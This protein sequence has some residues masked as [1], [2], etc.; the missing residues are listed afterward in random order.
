MKA[1]A[2]AGNIDAAVETGTFRAEGTLALRQAVS[3]VWS[4]ELSDELHGRAVARYGQ[5]PGIT[6]VKG[7]SDAVLPELLGSIDEPA[8]FW[9]DAH[10]GM[11][12]MLSDTVFNPADEATQ[13]P[14]VAELQALRD[15]AHADRSCILIDDAR[16][17]L[18]PLP[19]HRSA[20]WPTLLDIVDLVRTGSDRH[21]TI[22]DDVI[23][24]V[25]SALRTVVDDWWLGVVQTREG[26]DGHQQNLWEAYNP[27]PAVAARRLVKSLTPV[28]LRRLY[29][30]H[31]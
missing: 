18:G 21:V 17:F 24:C 12:D 14:I 16:A 28:A 1:L 2:G 30:R 6:F 26:R 25:P 31:R 19:G 22:L 4:V 11:V 8:I 29:E 10:G 13:C 27:T 3:R 15:F 7:S 23:I 20:D 5:R 9:L